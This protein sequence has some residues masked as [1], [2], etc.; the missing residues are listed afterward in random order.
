MVVALDGGAPGR[1][2]CQSDPDGLEVYPTRRD[3][4]AIHPTVRLHLSLAD[5]KEQFGTR[6]DDAFIPVLTCRNCGQ[7]FF[8]KWYTDLKLGTG[9]KKQLQDFDDGNATQNDDGSENAWWATSP[10]E[11]GTRLLLTNRLLEEADGGPS[12]KSTR[13]PKAWFC[14]QCGA[15]HRNSSP[16]CLADGCGHKEPLLPL[17]AFGSRLYVGR[18]AQRTAKTLWEA[19]KKAQSG[20]TSGNSA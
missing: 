17:M 19:H 10:A 20:N 18:N 8:E 13:W 16:R 4:L 2:D 6:H 15:M 5:A 7:H 11:T 1:W 12:A 3:G 14:R 9:A